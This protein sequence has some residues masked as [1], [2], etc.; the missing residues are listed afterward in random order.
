MKAVICT[1]YGPPDVLKL[2]EIGKPT[3]RDNEV[4]I[5]IRAATVTMGDCEIRGFRMPL[6]IW[7]PARIG[8]GFRGPRRKILGQELAGEV[9]AVGRDVKLFGKG[10]QVFAATGFNLGAYAEYTCLP[11]DGALA[12]KPVNTTYEEAATVPTGGLTALHFLRKAKIQS[13]QKVLI[14]GA[15]GSIGTLAIQLAKH[16][17][18]EVTGVDSTGKLDMVKSIGADHVIDYTKEDFTASGESYKVIFDVVGK[19]SFSRSI[20]SLKPGGRYLL[21]NPGLAQ[22]ARGSFT[23]RTSNRKVV[24]GQPEE[25]A[26]DL[27]FLRGLIETHGVRPVVDRAYTLDRIVE[28]H[29]YVESGRKKGNVVITV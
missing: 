16:F 25:K 23:S 27:A 10:D 26:E 9:A 7:L 21:A 6:W 20:V 1:K 17:G 3:P 19:S 5:R 11:E 24:F 22:M 8:F 13:G 29:R 28:A 14:N 2:E 18:A 15:G 12:T 4:L